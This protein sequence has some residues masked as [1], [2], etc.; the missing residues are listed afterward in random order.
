MTLNYKLTYCPSRGH[1]WAHRPS[2]ELERRGSG[3]ARAAGLGVSEGAL[4]APQI[5]W[6]WDM[7]LVT[8]RVV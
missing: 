4:A 1:M 6:L 7:G 2:Q 5:C 3:K 8:E